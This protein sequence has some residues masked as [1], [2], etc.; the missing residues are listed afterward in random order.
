MQDRGFIIS[1]CTYPTTLEQDKNCVH[2]KLKN[3]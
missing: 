2:D 1:S 3:V